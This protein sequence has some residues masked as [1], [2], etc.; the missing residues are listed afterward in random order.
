M[1]L[2]FAA[3]RV[4]HAAIGSHGGQEGEMAERASFNRNEIEGRKKKVTSV[5]YAE[6]QPTGATVK[7]G[8]QKFAHQP[9][10]QVDLGKEGGKISWQIDRP[11]WSLIKAQSAT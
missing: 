9:T 5:A 1:E 11:S 10:R 8:K 3:G 6:T 7:K 2:A 4:V